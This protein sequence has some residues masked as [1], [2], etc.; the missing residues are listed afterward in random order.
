MT[1]R[2]HMHVRSR[3]AISLLAVCAW[4]MTTQ[5][6]S[7][8]SHGWRSPGRPP[9]PPWRSYHNSRSTPR[10]TPRWRSH[11]RPSSGEPG[12][13]TARTPGHSPGRRY[14]PHGGSCRS[15][16]S[17]PRAGPTTRGATYH[18]RPS[19]GE[20]GR[21]RAPR[22]LL[23]HVLSLLVP[24]LRRAQ[25]FGVSSRMSDGSGIRAHRRSIKY[26]VQMCERC[27]VTC[28]A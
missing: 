27:A 11:G 15:T 2:S 8:S 21:H 19:S 28:A 4:H 13:R 22:P 9:R 3:S 18:G 17:T 7:A 16:E 5:R 14:P 24:P 1:W 23:P 26:R 10:T 25:C 20:P 12:R 6:L